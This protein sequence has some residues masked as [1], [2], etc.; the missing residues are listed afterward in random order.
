MVYSGR[1]RRRWAGDQPARSVYLI[2]LKDIAAGHHS[3]GLDVFQVLVFNVIMFLLAEISLLG[4][5]LAP[6][7][8]DG[9]SRDWITGCRQ[10]AAGSRSWSRRSSARF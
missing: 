9:S 1:D 7:R 3:T 10:T 4:L 5:I 8:T 2:A 6:E